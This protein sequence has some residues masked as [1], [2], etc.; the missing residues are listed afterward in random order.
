MSL[1][2]D[3]IAWIVAGGVAAVIGV[4]TLGGYQKIKLKKEA[5][6]MNKRVSDIL[7]TNRLTHFFGNDR[8][9]VSSNNSNDS[10]E[11]LGNGKGKKSRRRHKNTKRKSR[12]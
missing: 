5:D 10:L 1:P 11:D 6:N 4:A 12:K 7:N 8:N 9:S 3:T 2:I